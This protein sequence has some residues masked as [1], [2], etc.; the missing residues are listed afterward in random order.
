MIPYLL[1]QNWIQYDAREI[2]PALTAAGASLLSLRSTP[3]LRSWAD[4]LRVVQL[5][6]E[7]AGTSRIE[8]ADFTDE[9]L[10]QALSE[11]PE[12]LITRSQKQAAAA[13]RT[14]RW[15]ETL[16]SD[17]SINAD[18][19]FEIHRRIITGADDDHCPPG[20][21]RAQDQN[22]TF[23][24]P[25]HRGVEGGENCSRAFRALITA[26]ADEFRPHDSLVQALAL[27]Y[28]FAAMHP[29]LDGNGRTARALE[30]VVLGKAG[31]KDVLFISMS[32]Y[33][34]EE[35][36]AYLQ[37]LANARSNHHDL[38]EFLIFGLKGVEIQCTRLSSEIRKN[39]SK[40]LY[41]N[42]MYDL[43]NRL[44]GKRKRVIANRQIAILKVLLKED[45]LPLDELA[46]R[47]GMHYRPL[48]G[49]RSAW[50][51]D[52]SGLLEL[53]AIDFREDRGRV[54]LFPRLEWPTE[55]TETEFFERLQNLPQAKTYPFL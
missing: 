53:R 19:V 51:R 34:Y 40:A 2:A 39:L 24:T 35:K 45:E 37:S 26:V 52:I 6:R 46:Q 13:A 33:Y 38:T 55:I 49:V 50:I 28:H 44:E 20:L 21:L 11:D 27:H 4:D 9:E 36:N 12:A 31:L 18:L 54:L 22:V 15:I 25:R 10:E 30:A 23:G 47:V 48:K 17:R 41:R 16:P 7:V 32:N 42:L 43:F 1:P 29:F 3:Y 14:Y 8:G 5:K